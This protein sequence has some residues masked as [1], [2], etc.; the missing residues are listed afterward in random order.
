MVVITVQNYV[1]AEVYTITAGSRK[2]FWV[3]M[4]DVQK[5]LGIQ[6]IS[7]LVRKDIQDIYDT[8]DFKKTKKKIYKD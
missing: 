4:I 3:K 2:L 7:D 1:D 6:N 8:E 5:G